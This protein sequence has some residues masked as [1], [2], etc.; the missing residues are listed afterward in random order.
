VGVN[1]RR[2]ISVFSKSIH[3]GQAYKDNGKSGIC[4][5]SN[6]TKSKKKTIIELKSEK[7][8]R[9]QKKKKIQGNYLSGGTLKASEK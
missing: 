3:R 8:G 1:G 5:N 6:K 7:I 9:R 2:A 4:T